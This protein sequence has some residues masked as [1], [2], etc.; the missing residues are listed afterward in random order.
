MSNNEVFIDL[1]IRHS[2][3]DI[4]FYRNIEQSDR[5]AITLSLEKKHGKNYNTPFSFQNLMAPGCI[6]VTIP[7]TPFLMDIFLNVFFCS[8]I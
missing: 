1:N 3:I 2:L 5:V 6:G 8:T 4:L 7:F